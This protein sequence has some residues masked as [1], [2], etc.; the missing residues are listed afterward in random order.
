MDLRFLFLTV[1][2]PSKTHEY[3]MNWS[4]W[5]ILKN[6]LYFHFWQ[7]FGVEEKV[8]SLV[9]C[10]LKVKIRWKFNLLKS[11]KI[12]GIKAQLI[13]KPCTYK[14]ILVLT[15][16]SIVFYIYSFSLEYNS[17]NGFQI[18]SAEYILSFFKCVYTIWPDTVRSRVLH[19]IYL[20]IIWIHIIYE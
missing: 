19:Y 12:F 9:K 3:I 16:Y 5:K 11:L 2:C 18:Q 14:Q 4:F 17:L 8:G 13:L 1:Y 10:W 15:I 6:N 20:H 7:M